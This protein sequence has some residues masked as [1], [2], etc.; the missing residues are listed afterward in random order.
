[1]SKL[2]TRGPQLSERAPKPR[3]RERMPLRSAAS[4]WSAVREESFRAMALEAAAM[5]DA[6]NAQLADAIPPDLVWE[7]LTY[8]RGARAAVLRLLQQLHGVPGALGLIRRFTRTRCSTPPGTQRRTRTSRQ[9]DATPS[10][11]TGNS[12]LQKAGIQIHISTQA[13][14]WPPTPMSARAPWTRSTITSSTARP[15]EGTRA[16]VS[17]PS[18]T[19]RGS[20]RCNERHQPASPFHAVRGR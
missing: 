9:V 12:A 5:R 3:S 16:L 11:T 7:T 8:P 13:G 17:T 1:M 15:K 19:S 10:V 6:A 14:I 20:R 4:R 2:P 18:G